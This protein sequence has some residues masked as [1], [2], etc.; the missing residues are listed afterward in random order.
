M[1]YAD[2]Y[3]ETEFN[4]LDNI[5][6]RESKW[7]VVPNAAGGAAFG[8]PQAMTSVHR[9]TNNAIWKSSPTLQIEWLLNYI[10][11]R[12]GDAC[13]AWRYKQQMNWY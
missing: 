1:A 9:E 3:S 11:G 10:D 13:K 4:C 5:I 12:Y 8:I 6:N 7:Y 2:G